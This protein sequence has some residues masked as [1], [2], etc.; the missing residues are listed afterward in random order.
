MVRFFP[1]PVFYKKYFS[2]YRLIQ[3]IFVFKKKNKPVIQESMQKQ[4]LEQKND[5]KFNP[6]QG[7]IYCY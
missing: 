2:Y 4:G 3:A 1:V 7:N 6:E 5:A